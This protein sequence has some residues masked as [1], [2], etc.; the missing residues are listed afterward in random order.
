MF[1]YKLNSFVYCTSFTKIPQDHTNVRKSFFWALNLINMSGLFSTWFA[2]QWCVWKGGQENSGMT[3]CHNVR[4]Y[5]LLSSKHSGRRSSTMATEPI[6]GPPGL[7][8]P[9][10]P[11][12]PW[13]FWLS[14]FKWGLGT[15][16][17]RSPAWFLSDGPEEHWYH[18]WERVQWWRS[19]QV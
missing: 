3:K 14:G 13:G 7:P 8:V 1:I 6:R 17:F 16:A 11:C 18:G 5:W 10:R 12:D 15:C 9:T 4:P 2:P 19:L